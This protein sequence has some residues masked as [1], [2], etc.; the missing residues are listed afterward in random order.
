MAAEFSD[1]FAMDDCRGIR[2]V[3]MARGITIGCFGK[4]PSPT[5]V[6]VRGGLTIIVVD[7]FNFW[8]FCH[9]QSW[10]HDLIQGC[11]R[12]SVSTSVSAILDACER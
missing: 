12:C 6:A 10:C 3:E 8:F 4:L 9:A 11:N 7:G 1:S 2:T 5:K